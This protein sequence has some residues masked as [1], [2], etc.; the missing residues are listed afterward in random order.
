VSFDRAFLL[1]SAPALV[2]A[3]AVAGLVFVLAAVPARARP[4]TGLRGAERQRA[5]ASRLDF[6]VIEPCMRQLAAWLSVLE[7]SPSR[8][9]P[10]EWGP[11]RK[12]R[13]RYRAWQERQIL[14]SGTAW[15]LDVE[16]LAALLLMSAL[17]CAFLGGLL[18]QLTGRGW[19]GFLPG[20]LFGVAL[21]NLQLSSIIAAR[22]KVAARALPAAIDVAALCMSAG[23]DFPQALRLVVQGND[24]LIARELG[25]VLSMLEVGRTRR[26]AFE[27]LALRLPAPAVCDLVRALIQADEKGNPLVEV[28]Q[29]QA[30]MSRMRRSVAAEEAAA[31]AG[32]LM[33]VP[34]M[35]LM[36]TILLLLLGPF[37]ATGAGL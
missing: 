24:D 37:I 31:R 13:G 26:V 6:S 1:S 2:L 7:P 29:N 4:L 25:H 32:V 8:S 9:V 11:L 14:S 19:L 35:L 21:P 36:G 15:G 28:L 12:V 20:A 22:L 17:V 5:L 27:E 3:L 33:I 18:S 30:R 23:A 34:L 10:T 16:E